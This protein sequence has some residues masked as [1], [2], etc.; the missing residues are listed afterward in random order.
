MKILRWVLLL[1]VLGAGALAFAFRGDLAVMVMQRIA[2]RAMAADMIATLPDGLHVGLCGTG[3]PLPDP[4]RSG[5]CTAVIAGKRL[6]IVDAGDGAARMTARMT[7]SASRME[8]VLLTHFHSDHIDGLGA[9]ALMRWAGGGG[10][11]PLPVHGPAG[12][13]RIVNGF[14]EAYAFD[15]GYRVAHHG[16]DIVAPQGAGMAAAPFVFPEGVDAMVV[17]EG[18]GLRVTAF[19][20]D[21]APISPAVGY[22]FDYGG[23]S[24]VISGD[25]VRSGS[26]EAAAKDADLLVHEALAPGL[27]ALLETAASDTGRTKLAK[28]FKDIP[29]YHTSPADAAASATAAGVKALVLTHIV[30]AMPTRA[31]EPAFMNGATFSGPFWIGRDGDFISLPAGTQAITRRNLL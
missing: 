16:A 29:D 20:V 8:A 7:L 2:P 14:N 19:R 5:P 6:F 23:R 26:L 10:Q 17:M 13:E 30:P 28:I 22:R 24:V 31:L 9:L 15:A 18:D 4:R 1:A 12:V 25:T 21:H 11:A 3:S 27:V